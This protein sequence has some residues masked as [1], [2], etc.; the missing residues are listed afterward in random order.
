MIYPPLKRRDRALVCT[1]VKFRQ[2]YKLET[3]LDLGV[4]VLVARCEAS[5]EIVWTASLPQAPIIY[6][7]NFN[8]SLVVQC[9]SVIMYMYV[10]ILVM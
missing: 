1:S 4:L 8:A 6:D 7:I 2:Q 9:R 5:L 3:T 10:I